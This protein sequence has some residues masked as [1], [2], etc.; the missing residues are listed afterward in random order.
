LGLGKD[1]VSTQSKETLFVIDT[2]SVVPLYHQIKE[3]VRDLIDHDL[4]KEGEL[5][6][7]ERDLSEIYGV[8]R[9]TVRQ[10]LNELVREGLL[11]RQRGIGTF[12]ATPRITHALG[13]VKGFSERIKKAG[14]KPSSK[15]LS[16]VITRA[17]LTVARRLQLASH[18]EVYQLTRLRYADGKPVMLETAYLSSSRFPALL[19]VNFTNKSLY[20]VLAERYDCHIQ[21]ADETLEPVIM[22]EYEEQIL[23]VDSGVPGLLVEAVAYNQHKVPVEL[24]RSV[25]RGDKSRFYF[26]VK[27]HPEST[28][29][30]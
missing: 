14:H 7:S 18:T 21:E 27:R 8:S 29:L 1:S 6:P 5:I 3:N 28:H 4:L 9:L 16:F 30:A 15:V 10:A 11:E 12:V 20:Q 13:Q 24:G 23:E 22:S 19:D 2:D 26:R 25:V 17:P